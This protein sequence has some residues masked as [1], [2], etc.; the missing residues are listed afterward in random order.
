MVEVL[1]SSVL[2]P[3]NFDRSPI[4]PES[5]ECNRRMFNKFLAGIMLFGSLP[6]VHACEP[7]KP[8]PKGSLVIGG[9]GELSQEIHDR[10]IELAGGNN[11]HIV[12][13]PTASEYADDPG[14]IIDMYWEGKDRVASAI[15]LHTR[16]REEANKSEF[17][18]PLKEATGVWISG[19]QQSLLADAYVGTLVEQE[20]DN[21]LKRGGV[22][23]GTSAGA[24]ILSPVMIIR[25][26]P[27]PTL[28]EGFHFLERLAPRK[29]IV[30]QHFDTR[31]RIHRL[32]NALESHPERVGVGVC[33]GAALVINGCEA[34]V[35]N[36]NVWLCNAEG[37]SKEY[38]PGEKVDLNALNIP[39]AIARV[40]TP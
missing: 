5:E 14:Q 28:G 27:T 6:T 12:V 16:S 7:K 24:A 1:K 15:L 13:I 2:A 8:V 37:K 3:Q 35:M 10:F 33:W 36:K 23:G 4:L 18:R 17:V 25:G 39:T 32:V 38:V 40:G 9:G 11:A 29:C 31:N 34:I 22:V 30:D 20:L 21:V 19:G 26:N